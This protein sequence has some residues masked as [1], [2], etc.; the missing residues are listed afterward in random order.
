M[1]RDVVLPELRQNGRLLAKITIPVFF[2]QFSMTF[3]GVVN[4]ALAA[5]LGNV[6]V[7]AIGLVDAITATLLTMISSLAVGG[8]VAVAR[9][10]G[11]DD[12]VGIGVVAQQ[13]ILSILFLGTIVS[14]LAWVTRVPLIHL[15][16]GGADADVLDASVTFYGLIILSMPAWSYTTVVSGV[17]RGVGDT[18]TTMKVSVIMS[19]ANILL[20][21]LFIK[22]L[23]F[24]L[25]AISIHFASLGIR[26]TALGILCARW[27]GVVAVSIPLIHSR[28]GSQRTIRMSGLRMYRPDMR[29]LREVFFIGV[30][31]SAESAIFQIGKLV[32]Q[33]LVVGLGTATLAANSISVSVFGLFNI[34]GSAASTAA[35]TLVGQSIG[36]G[37]KR[38]SRAILLTMMVMVSSSYILMSLLLMGFLRPVIGAYTV[39][40]EVYA[41]VRGLLISM[42]IPMPLLWSA[43][44]LSAS[45]LRAAGDVRFTMLVSITSMWVMRVGGAFLFIRVFRLGIIGL[46]LSMYVDWFV[47]SI[48]FGTRILGDKWFVKSGIRDG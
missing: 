33:T 41:I 23:D 22:G 13:S 10:Y 29:V 20:S 24:E 40:P 11:R 44:F 9:A 35:T 17:L 12:P 15:L 18:R 8:T 32:T 34:P 36:Q 30:P 45:G 39:N 7:S 42:M 16:Y 26:G 1:L 48:V 3:M 4:T 37:D 47:R 28:H 21:F 19:I 27:I 2:E 38:K 14:V 46:W 31:A 6:V 5:S 43:S 25:G